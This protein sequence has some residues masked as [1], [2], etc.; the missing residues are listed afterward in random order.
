MTKDNPETLALLELRE[1]KITM[2]PTE[3]N[4]DFSNWDFA[5]ARQISYDNCDADWI[6]YLD[7]DDILTN[8]QN[9][10]PLIEKAEQDGYDAVM[11]PYDYEPN[12]IYSKE[13]VIK[14]G[15]YHWRGLVHECLIPNKEVKWVNSTDVIVTHKSIPNNRNERN[16]YLIEK[17]Y[18]EAKTSRTVFYCGK[19][20]MFLGKVPE[21]IKYFKEYLTMES[22]P[23]EKHMAYMLLCRIDYENTLEHCNNAIKLLP[24][25]AEPYF[26]KARCYFDRKDYISCVNELRT[27]FTKKL[28]A[29]FGI[30]SN[31]L[32]F[33]EYPNKLME[34]SISKLKS[35]A[36]DLINR[37]EITHQELAIINKAIHNEVIT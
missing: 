16:L 15:A 35:I 27:G 14:K 28:E 24:E 33:N 31:S 19:D 32:E 6:I 1:C 4:K 34:D 37:I 13:R 17:E 21:A 18:K 25:Y 12:N 7:T 10:R 9:L 2:L 29:P 8:P 11:L 26:K 36:Y 3:W 20:S 30:P 22:N 23:A 5:A